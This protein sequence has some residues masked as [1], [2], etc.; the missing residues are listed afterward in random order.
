MQGKRILVSVNTSWNIVNFRSGLMRDL[1]QQGCEVIVAAPEDSYS[2]R[3][4][5]LGCR[6]VPLAMDSHGKSPI[7]DLI[8]MSRFYQILRRER[9]H[10]FLGYTAKP[11]IFGSLAA[12]A[13]HIPVINNIAGLGAAFADKTWLTETVKYLYRIAINRSHKVFFQNSEDL[14]LF[15]DAG[16]AREE[17][18]DLLPGS[19][20]DLSRFKPAERDEHAAG[21]GALR[22]LFVGRLLW[23]KGIG[24]YVEA[25]RAMK[26][27]YPEVRFQIIGATDEKNPGAVSQATIQEWMSDQS[28]EYLGAVDD[29][30][31]MIA[32]AD[33]IVLPTYYREGTPRSLLEAA[34][35]AKPIITTDWVGSR[36]VVDDAI[37]GFLCQARSVEDLLRKM[38]AMVHLSCDQ[39]SAMGAAGREKVV[40][41]FDEQL[42]VERYN[43]AIQSALAMHSPVRAGGRV[44]LRLRANPEGRV[45]EFMPRRA[46]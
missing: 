14:R 19:G 35:M 22:F 12:H 10:V 38:E 17:R 13:L 9:P 8:L 39:R 2:G 18:C 20:V 23:E 34:A 21:H 26:E 25:A 36:N 1:V 41:E 11:N 30:R 40:R 3:I 6:Y 37:N 32:S 5:D 43:S 42:V 46:E 44:P 29:V 16:L 24:E 28:I 4:S 27:K 33:C 31:P 15:L 45:D 7:N